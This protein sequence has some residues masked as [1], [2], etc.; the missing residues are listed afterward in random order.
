TED[1][2]ANQRKRRENLRKRPDAEAAA[3]PAL[4]LASG[5]DAYREKTTPHRRHSVPPSCLELHLGQTTLAT[6]PSLLIRVQRG[7]SGTRPPR[8]LKPPMN[9]DPRLSMLICGFVHALGWR[10]FI[11][12]LFP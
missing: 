6:Q 5:E 2:T 12:V 4:I 1:P 9:T 8:T 3:V 10:P 11:R 7:R